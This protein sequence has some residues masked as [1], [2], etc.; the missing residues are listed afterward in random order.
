MVDRLFNVQIKERYEYR[1]L[2]DKKVIDEKIPKEIKKI[3]NI[4][5]E[6]EAFNFFFIIIK[7]LKFYL[8]WFLYIQLY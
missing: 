6:N 5:S 8:F 3:N 7:N 1:D 4:F 2:I